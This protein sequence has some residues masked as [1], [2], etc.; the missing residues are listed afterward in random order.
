LKQITLLKR[1]I[2]DKI[3]GAFML[4]AYDEGD[5]S[6]IEEVKEEAWTI[7]IAPIVS[8]VVGEAK[9]MPWR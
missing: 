8:G 5:I 3:D 7:E 9:R 2:V 4:V 1:Y 6:A